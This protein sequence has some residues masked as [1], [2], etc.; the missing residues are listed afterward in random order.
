MDK[1]GGYLFAGRSSRGL[2]QEER[3]VPYPLPPHAGATE[4]RLVC[5]AGH[6]LEQTERHAGECERPLHKKP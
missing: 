6:H 1:Y 4:R 3:A 5:T 2:Y